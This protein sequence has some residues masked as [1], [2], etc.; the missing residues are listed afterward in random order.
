MR[1]VVASIAAWSSDVGR[2]PVRVDGGR[3]AQHR[4]Q[5][6]ER[7]ER[8]RTVLLH[9]AEQADHAERLAGPWRSAD[10]RVSPTETPAVRAIAVSS[11]VTARS[12]PLLRGGVPAAGGEAIGERVFAGT[13]HTKPGSSRT[14]TSFT[15]AGWAS[16]TPDVSR[17]SRAALASRG[18]CRLEPTQTCHRWSLQLLRVRLPIDVP[19]P[20]TREQRCDGERDLQRRRE[21]AALSP[22]DAAQADLRRPRQE[23]DVPQRAVDGRRVRTDS[24]PLASSAS[25]DRHADGAANR[26]QRGQH[27]AGEPDQDARGEDRQDRPPSCAGMP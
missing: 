11:T 7:D 1:V 14:L 12:R 5:R 8:D 20:S 4:L 22:A 3:R 19:R 6:P 23:R 18:C 21:A 15:N 24:A 13:P 17:I 26:G 2:D 9:V 27:R 10:G 25:R 16:A